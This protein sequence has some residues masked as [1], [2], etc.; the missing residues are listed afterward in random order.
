APVIAYGRGGSLDIVEDGVSGVLFD[1]QTINSVVNA[2]QKAESIKF[3]PGTL[4]RK[5]K[6][7]D[8]SLF[9]T[10]IRKVVSDQSIRL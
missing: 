10:K 9:I 2:I 6:R 5:A 4:R 1:H 8:K 7:F 3:L